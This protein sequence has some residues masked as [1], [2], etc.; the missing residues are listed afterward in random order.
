[1]EVFEQNIIW[2]SKTLAELFGC[3]Q[4]AASRHQDALGSGR[5]EMAR[6]GLLWMIT[7]QKLV[8]ARVPANG[9]PMLLRTWLSE[10]RHGMYLRQYVVAAAHSGA[11]ICR[12]AAVWTLVDAEKRALA[13]EPLPIPFYREE[14]QLARFPLLRPM[15]TARTYRFTVPREYLDENGHMNNARYFDAVTEILPQ[16]VPHSVQ[17]DYHTEALEGET[18]AVGYTVREKGI[19]VQAQGDRGLCFRMKLSYGAG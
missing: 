2:E 6:R 1:M 10:G 16:G 19:E 14:G 8:L 18:L 7:R 15:E 9:E 5:E 13:Q 17:A 4:T 12:A 3:L 11:V